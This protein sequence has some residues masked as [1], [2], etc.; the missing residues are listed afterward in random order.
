MNISLDTLKSLAVIYGISIVYEKLPKGLLGKANA[1]TK[2]I[3]LDVL[4]KDNPRQHKCVLAEEIGH[5]I[6]PPR[7]GHIRYHSLDS[8]RCENFGLTKTIVAQ[9]ERKALDWAT[10]VLIPNVEFDR[11]MAKGSYTLWE[12]EEV[13]EVER[14]LVEHKIGYY[15]RKQRDMGRRVKWRDLIRR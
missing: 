1:E 7:P 6:I 12:I 10:G 2:T 14:W 15:R 3:T 4:L 5:I 11:I 9:D 8:W 13:F